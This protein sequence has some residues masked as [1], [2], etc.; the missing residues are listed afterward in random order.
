MNKTNVVKKTVGGEKVNYN[1]E[2][3][4]TIYSINSMLMFGEP[5]AISATDVLMSEKDIK[6][7]K[8]AKPTNKNI[9]VDI[10]SVDGGQYVYS[11]YDVLIPDDVSYVKFTANA[12][13]Y[14]GLHFTFM[15]SMGNG[16]YEKCNVSCTNFDDM[17]WDD[18]MATIK[19]YSDK[20]GKTNVKNFLDDF[21]KDSNVDRDADFKSPL[22]LDIQS[23]LG[24]SKLIE[25]TLGESNMTEISTFDTASA[26]LLLSPIVT[27]SYLSADYLNE[28]SFESTGEFVFDVEHS[29]YLHTNND[30]NNYMQVFGTTTSYSED[31]SQI[32][33]QGI[34]TIPMNG[35]MIETSEEYAMELVES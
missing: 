35:T 34:N 33:T 20:I 1:R 5:C 13:S 8:I 31:I 24:K 17:A 29:S 3:V 16:Q 19:A 32:K 23:K 26:D 14:A 2:T 7:C 25:R 11:Y 15:N 27:G 21:I 30:I 6:R 10:R 4:C 9:P 28:H 22:I 12:D 18:S